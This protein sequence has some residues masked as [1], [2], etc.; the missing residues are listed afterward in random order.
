MSTITRFIIRSTRKR[1]N[2]ELWFTTREKAA[3]FVRTFTPYHQGQ[4]W[5]AEELWQ[6]NGAAWQPPS[7][8]RH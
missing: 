5:I 6:W 3:A 4:V 8:A 1:A 2:R 7:Q